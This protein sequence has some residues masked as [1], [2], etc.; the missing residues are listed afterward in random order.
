MK[1]SSIEIYNKFQ[2]VHGVIRLNPNNSIEKT[3]AQMLL[4]YELMKNFM[5]KALKQDN[6]SYNLIGTK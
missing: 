4:G 1:S 6:F 3:G 5:G 2:F